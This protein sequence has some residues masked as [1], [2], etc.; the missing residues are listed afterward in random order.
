MIPPAT[1]LSIMAKSGP[2]DIGSQRYQSI[3]C[4]YLGPHDL[5]RR[6]SPSIA[7]TSSPT[8]IVPVTAQCCT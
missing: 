6:P 8:P 7:H 4:Q 5:S 2:N 1:M 3:A